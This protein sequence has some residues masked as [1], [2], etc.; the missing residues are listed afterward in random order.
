MLPNTLYLIRSLFS[1]FN[2]R[3]HRAN[4]LSNKSKR[5]KKKSKETGL[6]LASIYIKHKIVE[7]LLRS[8]VSFKQ[9]YWAVYPFL[10]CIWNKCELHL[11]FVSTPCIKHIVRRKERKNCF[12][13]FKINIQSSRLFRKNCYFSFVKVILTKTNEILNPTAHIEIF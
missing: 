13:M 2:L 4:R 1:R 9:S 5:V 8:I 7:Y 6:A 12:F 11:A 3:Y 10:A